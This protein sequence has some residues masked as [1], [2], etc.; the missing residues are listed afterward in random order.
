MEISSPTVKI[1]WENPNRDP[2]LAPGRLVFLFRCLGQVGF[3][4]HQP[5][6]KKKTAANCP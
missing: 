4:H 3:I 2:V 5:P 6:P 1:P